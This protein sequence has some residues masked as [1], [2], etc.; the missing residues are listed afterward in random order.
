MKPLNRPETLNRHHPPCGNCVWLGLAVVGIMGRQSA[1][2]SATG[3][4]SLSYLQRKALLHV[5]LDP[6]SKAEHLEKQYGCAGA[7]LAVPKKMHNSCYLFQNVQN[8]G[9][10][11]FFSRTSE[12]PNRFFLHTDLYQTSWA[13]QW[14][15]DNSVVIC[16][17]TNARKVVLDW[18]WNLPGTARGNIFGL[19]P[20]WITKKMCIAKNRMK[21]TEVRVEKN[22]IWKLHIHGWERNIAWNIKNPVLDPFFKKSEPRTGCLQVILR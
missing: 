6:W 11:L 20:T 8:E 18:E 13:R 5:G 15:N 9:A 19:V 17:G 14:K 4:P 3:R 22:N 2:P 16:M 7:K 10:S 21:N 12:L 1:A